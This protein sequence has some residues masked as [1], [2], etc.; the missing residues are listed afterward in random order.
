MSRPRISAIVCTHGRPALVSLAVASLV[1]QT[2]SQ[3][4]YEIVVVDNNPLIAQGPWIA[5]D[6]CA[7][8]GAGVPQALA[9]FAE[10]PN[11]R[12]L[13]EPTLGL[14]PARNAGWRAARGEFVAYLDD[15]AIAAPGWL[16]AIL[17]VFDARH[18]QPGAVGG[19]VVPRW[20]AAPPAWLA[21]ELWPN[22][23]LVDWS[24][25]PCDLGADRWLPGCNMALPR[26]RL[27]EIGGFPVALGRR[28]GRLFGMEDT[29]VQARLRQAG[30]AIAFDPAV[31][32]THLVPAD[33]LR[34][35]WFH[36]R[37]FWNGVSLARARLIESPAAGRARLRLA[38]SAL[39]QRLLQ[40]RVWSCWLPGDPTAER[41]ASQ[42]ACVGWLGYVLGVLVDGTAAE[43]GRCG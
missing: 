20:A 29:F 32:V 15:D 25:R 9:A 23:S 35:A 1:G 11:L 18:P 3:A 33:R 7:A 16:T 31:R 36:R 28:G 39:R 34:P 38:R 19:P 41:V 40:G 13:H 42:C 26:A 6:S 12:Y 14:A 22:L 17:E 2:L 24:D 30:L 43:R 27:A 4:D 10:V 8:R 5:Q 21:P 37:A